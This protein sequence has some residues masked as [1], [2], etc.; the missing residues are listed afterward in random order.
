MIWYCMFHFIFLRFSA[1]QPS[2]NPE[3]HNIYK[4]NNYYSS[5]P[6]IPTMLFLF[7]VLPKRRMTINYI[8]LHHISCVYFIV[9]L[10]NSRRFL[11]G[12]FVGCLFSSPPATLNTVQFYVLMY[13]YVRFK[14]FWR[15]YGIANLLD[16]DVSR[17]L[18]VIFVDY[19]LLVDKQFII[20]S[21]W[22][23]KRRTSQH[24]I[25]KPINNRFKDFRVSKQ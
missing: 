4:S 20:A 18:I 17:R 5:T 12:M 3:N 11:F 19:V 13:F 15:R 21:K 14:C 16:K 6:M 22:T 7:H 8:I 10:L 9:I 25:Y 23:P 2:D 24:Y 1:K